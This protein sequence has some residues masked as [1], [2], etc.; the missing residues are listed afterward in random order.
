[1]DEGSVRERCEA[2]FGAVLPVA[3][4]QRG[5]LVLMMMEGRETLAICAGDYLAG[6]GENGMLFVPRAAGVCAWRV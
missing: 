3:F 5:D 4:A 6:P 2:L 1:M